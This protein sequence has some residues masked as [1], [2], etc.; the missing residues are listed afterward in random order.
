MLFFETLD[1]DCDVNFLTKPPVA[2]VGVPSGGRRKRGHADRHGKLSEEE[3][4]GDRQDASCQPSSTG[5]HYVVAGN[6]P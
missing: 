4:P 3:Q 2:D 6:Y 5:H 1:C